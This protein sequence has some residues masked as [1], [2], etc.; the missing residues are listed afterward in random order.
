LKKLFFVQK[1]L[2]ISLPIRCKELNNL[3]V[4]A[5]FVKRGRGKGGD[6]GIEGIEGIQEVEEVMK[7]VIEV[8]G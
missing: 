4:F 7:E 8:I 5:R 2:L 1:V 3:A 6:E